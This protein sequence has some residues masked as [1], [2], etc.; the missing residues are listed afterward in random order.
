MRGLIHYNMIE[1]EGFKTATFMD[2]LR[3][4]H[5]Q[6]LRKNRVALLLDNSSIHNEKTTVFEKYCERFDI[7]IIF[8]IKYRPD[9]NGIENVWGL[10]K[11]RYRAK[12][13]WHKANGV[14]WNNEMLV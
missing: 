6:K 5:N 12:I 8:N 7:Q 9:F 11:R 2:F 13:D 1:G 14:S 3:S 10:A 4:L